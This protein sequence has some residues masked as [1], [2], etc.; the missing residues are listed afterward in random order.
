MAEAAQ[1]S[2]E[3]IVCTVTAAAR[4]WVKAATLRAR[5]KIVVARAH[6]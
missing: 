2:R 6:G 4:S 1:R 5:I 3:A